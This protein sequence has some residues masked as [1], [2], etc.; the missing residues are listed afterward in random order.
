[1]YTYL[2]N[3]FT[4]L[5]QH[6]V[7]DASGQPRCVYHDFKL[8]PFAERSHQGKGVSRLSN[9]LS[10]LSSISKT[11]MLTTQFTTSSIHYFW[12]DDLGVSHLVYQY[13]K[14]VL[15]A[16][17]LWIVLIDKFNPASQQS[18]VNFWCVNFISCHFVYSDLLYRRHPKQSLRR[19]PSAPLRPGQHKTPD[20]KD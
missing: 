10:G 6:H 4:V 11:I 17:A 14:S 20:P 2:L 16:S 18:V 5:N 12:K 13:K 15:C 1:M 8:S 19:P 9:H 3:T 7:N